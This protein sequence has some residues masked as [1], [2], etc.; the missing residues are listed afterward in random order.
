MID[1]VFIVKGVGLVVIGMVL[2]GEVK[3]GDLFWL[4]GVN[5]LM[6]VCVLYV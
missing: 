5:K 2:S 1:C 4:I 3:V 6:C